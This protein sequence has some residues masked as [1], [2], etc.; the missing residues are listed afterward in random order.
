MKIKACFLMALAAGALCAQQQPPAQQPPP[1]TQQPKPQPP[2]QPPGAI[3]QEPVYVRRFSVGATLSVLGLPAMRKGSTNIVTETP[4]VDGLYT[5]EDVSRRVGFGLTVQGA[6]SERVAVSAGVF[7]RP[8]IGYKMAS[9][10]YE[11]TDNPNT[12]ADD[13]TYIVRNEETRFRYYD[14]PVTL[15]YYGK[16]R[17]DPG[18]RWFVESGGALRRVARVRTSISETIGDGDMTCCT[19]TPAT[20][21][22]RTIRG[23]VAGFGVQVIDPVGIRVVPQVRFTR[24][25]ADTFN[26]FSTATQ[27]NQL[28]AMVSLTF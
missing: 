11:G 3:L 8:N 21:A 22:R 16:D 1:T 26:S 13:R 5:T 9:D 4:A 24:W 20:P 28:E 10:I 23:V 15:R 12:A 7:M 27:R 2:P 25:G 6:I 19:A 18:A 14:I 17:H